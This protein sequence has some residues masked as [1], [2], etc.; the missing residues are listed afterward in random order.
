MRSDWDNRGETSTKF[1]D[2]WV[3]STGIDAT[4]TNVYWYT[5][6][7]SSPANTHEQFY[8]K[9]TTLMAAA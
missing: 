1:G 5:N 9:D 3:S 2:P 8:E 6:R 4:T 7:V